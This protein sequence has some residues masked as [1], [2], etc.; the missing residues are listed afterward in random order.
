MK[1]RPFVRAG[2]TD[3]S[4]F[5][6]RICAITHC[7]PLSTPASTASTASPVGVRDAATSTAAGANPAPERL[8]ST[9]SRLGCGVDRA[10]ACK[11]TCTLCRASSAAAVGDAVLAASGTLRDG[12][13]GDA[14]TPGV[15]TVLG[16]AEDGRAAGAE[17]PA[18]PIMISKAMQAGPAPQRRLFLRS[19]SA[20]REVIGTSC[21]I[22]SGPLGAAPRRAAL[23]GARPAV[24]RLPGR[25]GLRTLRTANVTVGE[26][27]A[28]RPAPHGRAAAGPATSP[29]GPG[30]RHGPP[31]DRGRG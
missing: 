28:P 15:A 4:R 2:N 18:T 19:R 8:A 31:A 17:H 10:N 21:H 9:C 3:V 6:D 23:A 30:R 27:V 25:H 26:A 13:D 12:P 14:V 11:A 1:Q 24:A 22:G 5:P 7:P 16:A 29:G 20:W